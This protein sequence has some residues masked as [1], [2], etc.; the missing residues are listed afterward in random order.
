MARSGAVASGGPRSTAIHNRHFH[1]PDYCACHVPRSPPRTMQGIA[2]AWRSIQLS[3]GRNRREVYPVSL[4]QGNIR[5]RRM[6]LSAC[7]R[8]T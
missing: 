3:Y 1:M 7:V 6:P 4:L 2:Q 8:L 5:C